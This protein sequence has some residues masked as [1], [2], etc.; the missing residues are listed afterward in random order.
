M[1]PPSELRGRP[2]IGVL[3][4]LRELRDMGRAI[5]ERETGLSGLANWTDETL[6]RLLGRDMDTAL[7]SGS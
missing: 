1:L 7:E 2:P 5:S 4:P 6:A 3:A